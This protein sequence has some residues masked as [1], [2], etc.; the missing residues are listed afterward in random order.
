MKYCRG[1]LLRSEMQ[2]TAWRG[3]STAGSRGAAR[4]V[5]TCR[6]PKYCG[7]P[8]RPCGEW[9]SCMKHNAPNSNLLK[10]MNHNILFK[11][12]KHIQG[13]TV[14][15]GLHDHI[16][17]VPESPSSKTS[18]LVYK[19]IST[20][21]ISNARSMTLAKIASRCEFLLSLLITTATTA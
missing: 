13:A 12:A 14:K 16:A 11:Y 7:S 1:M 5:P 9:S 8:A 17:P 20:V 3:V 19:P 6:Q 4:G 15:G 21:P 18:I 10:I 2:S